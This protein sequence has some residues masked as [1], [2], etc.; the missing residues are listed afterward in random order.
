MKTSKGNRRGFLKDVGWASLASGTLLGKSVSVVGAKAPPP[1]GSGMY[2]RL[3]LRPLINAKGTY[4]NLSGS[5][6]PREVAD[7][8]RQ[9]APQYVSIPELLEKIR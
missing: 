1:G 2:E 6:L 9:A 3:G 5:L 7:Q 8:M 4:T